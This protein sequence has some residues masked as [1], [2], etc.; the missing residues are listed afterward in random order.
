MLETI[1]YSLGIIALSVFLVIVIAGILTFLRIRAGILTL[2]Q[3]AVAQT[4]NMLSDRKK[5]IAS[6][7]GL[8]IAKFIFDKLK[9]GRSK[10]A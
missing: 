5:E 2:K 6:T 10:T 9:K 4:V 7:V 8:S 1:F 3:S